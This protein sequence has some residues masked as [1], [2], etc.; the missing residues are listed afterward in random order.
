MSGNSS[1]SPGPS[2][3]DVPDA[4]DAS[5][6]LGQGMSE[7]ITAL[8]ERLASHER[9]AADRYWARH[10]VEDLLADRCAFMDDL[11]RDI[12]Q[13]Q[14][15]A[16]AADDLSLLAVGGYGRGELFPHSD[17]DLLILAKRPQRWA[18]QISAFLRVLYDLNLEV[19]H[20]VRRLSECKQY[21]RGDIT[22]ATAMFE[23][24]LLSGSSKL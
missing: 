10:N 13:A 8:R 18:D 22:V 24:R 7:E 2:S 3:A 5:Q 16:K 21:A 19:G 14:I 12:W 15:P 4:N 9:L 23:R 11:I 17:I 1:T 6:R 20:S